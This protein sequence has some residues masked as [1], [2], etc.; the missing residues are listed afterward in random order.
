MRD[1][2]ASESREEQHRCYLENALDF[3]LNYIPHVEQHIKSASASALSDWLHS[4]NVHI[5]GRKKKAASRA[6]CSPASRRVAMK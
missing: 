2:S 5:T 6:V 4:A 3:V 1:R